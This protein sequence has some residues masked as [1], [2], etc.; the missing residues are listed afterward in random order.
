[1][2]TFPLAA[3]V[4]LLRQALSQMDVPTRQAYTMALAR[5]MAALARD[6]CRSEYLHMC[7]AAWGLLRV[8][9]LRVRGPHRAL[10]RIVATKKL[11]HFVPWTV[12]QSLDKGPSTMAYTDFGRTR[13]TRDCCMGDQTDALQACEEN[14]DLLDPL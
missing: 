10:Q 3:L 13:R 2:P 12:M 7:S 5:H 9:L 11:L 1:M 6:K 14:P 8:L 4:L